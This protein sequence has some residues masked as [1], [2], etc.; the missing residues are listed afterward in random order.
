MEIKNL[1]IDYCG[2]WGGVYNKLIIRQ[3]G[4]EANS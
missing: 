2:K 1:S 4:K 3:C